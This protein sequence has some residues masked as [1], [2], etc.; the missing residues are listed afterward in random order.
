MSIGSR[1]M[2]CLIYEE[3]RLGLEPFRRSTPGR[4]FGSFRMRHQG[5]AVPGRIPPTTEGLYMVQAGKPTVAVIVVSYNT[6]DLLREC[7]K[8]ALQENQSFPLDVCVVDNQSED[9]SPEMVQREFPQVRLLANPDNRGFAAANNQAYEQLT[10][11]YVV[12]LNPDAELQEG[13]VARIVAFMEEHPDCGLCGGRLLN[14]DG[15]TAPSARRFPSALNN[16]LILSG[17]SDRFKQHPFLGRADYGGF[18]HG[19]VKEVDWVPGTF[20]VIRSAMLRQI[21]FFDERYFMYYEETDLCLRANKNGWK[22]VYFPG[23]EVK[24]IG[25]ACSKTRQDHAMDQG[26]DQLLDYRMR[27]EFLYFRKNF[28][29]V[30]VLANAAV[31][32][33]WHGLRFLR[34]WRQGSASE[35]KRAYSRQILTHGWKA[36]RDTHLGKVSPP[37]PW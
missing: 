26:G 34:Y 16:F 37:K 4:V 27:A 12:L 10:N 22:V 1:P 11:D 35:P 28:G 3:T 7:L 6:A 25:G 32:L 14:S 5:N 9:G 29:L 31:E 30:S 2:A 20:T 18:D 24:H 23:A 15:S 36:L 13:A 19:S 8:S 33:G 17:L 21:G